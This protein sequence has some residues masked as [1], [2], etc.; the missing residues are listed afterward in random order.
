M[1]TVNEKNLVKKRAEL[2]AWMEAHQQLAAEAKARYVTM[3]VK[4]KDG[5]EAGFA[6]AIKETTAAEE[7]VAA[8]FDAMS[9]RIRL[10]PAPRVA[11]VPAKPRA[12][13]AKKEKAGKEA[14]PPQAPAA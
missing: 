7:K 8:S 11:G 13:R 1:R 10:A 2:Q 4:A 9:R 5:D 12:P 6:D 3:F 14:A